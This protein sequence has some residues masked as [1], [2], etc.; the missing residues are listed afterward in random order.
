MVSTDT[1]VEQYGPPDSGTTKEIQS[2]FYEEVNIKELQNEFSYSTSF[3]VDKVY[4]AQNPMPRQMGKS[5]PDAESFT[6]SPTNDPALGQF[7][8]FAYGRG[9][10]GTYGSLKDDHGLLI[11]QREFDHSSLGRA[12]QFETKARGSASQRDY[13]TNIF[14]KEIQNCVVSSDIDV[15]QFAF[16]LLA[17]PIPYSIKNP[18]DSSVSIRLGNYGVYP[19]DEDTVK[20]WLNGEFKTGLVVTPFFAGNGGL[21]II[22]NN[23]KEFSYGEQIDVRWE[24]FDTSIPPNKIDV[25]YWFR[26]VEDLSGPRIFNMSPVDDSVGNPIGTSISFELV[27]YES[28]VSLSSV[29]LYVNNILVPLSSP[30][31]TTVSI[32]GGYQFIYNTPTPFLYGDTIPVSV[33]VTDS[34]KNS[35]VSFFVWSFTTVNSIAP[36]L[37]EMSPAPCDTNVQRIKNISFEVID[38]GHGLKKESI[39]MGIN[40]LTKDNVTIVPIVRRLD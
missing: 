21:D 37:T 2:S 4:P 28:G 33:K 32:T 20:L 31:L 9:S 15:T 26:T 10:G 29:E 6:D 25:I 30:Y 12:G 23:N 5:T 14:T 27:D 40:N 34:S 17:S 18:V 16:L 35:N 7:Y 24:V 13:T 22:W 8:R 11:L 1:Y 3:R 19:L 38:G 39:V 36:L